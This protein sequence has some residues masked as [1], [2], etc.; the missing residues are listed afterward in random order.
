M[1]Q[2][3][4]TNPVDVAVIGLGAVGWA[5]AGR[6]L[7]NYCENTNQL[8]SGISLYGRKKSLLEL[9]KRI[10]MR[11]YHSQLGEANYVDT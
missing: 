9:Q 11:V 3:I 8:I 4:T 6:L 10:K 5:I 1:A 7:K 2:N